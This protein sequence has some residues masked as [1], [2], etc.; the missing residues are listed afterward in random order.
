[1]RMSAPEN[2]P[3][4]IESCRPLGPNS[5]TSCATRGDGSAKLV[6]AA[7]QS[8]EISGH[9]LGS[10]VFCDFRQCTVYGDDGPEMAAK[11][12]WLSG[13]SLRFLRPA[14]MSATR[15]SAPSSADVQLS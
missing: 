4:Q 7:V 14:A 10:L 1:M 3:P 12:I 13:S 8:W 5:R 9:G 6:S 15:S 2:S 11:M